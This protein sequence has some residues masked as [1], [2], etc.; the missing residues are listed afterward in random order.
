MGRKDISLTHPV[1]YDHPNDIRS[2]SN[3][4]SSYCV[5]FFVLPMVCM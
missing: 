4:G 1:L 5:I 3:A 2:K